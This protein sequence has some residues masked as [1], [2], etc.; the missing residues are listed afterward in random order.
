[1]IGT[2]LFFSFFKMLVFLILI[3]SLLLT[4]SNFKVLTTLAL[5]IFYTPLYIL[6]SL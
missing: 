6:D 4:F 1:M 2:P 5:L 3:L